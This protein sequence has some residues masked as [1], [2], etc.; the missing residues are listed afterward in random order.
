M[1]SDSYRSKY[2]THKGISSIK[3]FPKIV[4][5][6]KAKQTEKD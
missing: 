3:Q 5:F 6:L 4:I 2:Q 1:N